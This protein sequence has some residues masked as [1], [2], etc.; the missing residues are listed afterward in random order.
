MADE[1]NRK[2]QLPIDEAI[3]DKTIYTNK[4]NFRTKSIPEKLRSEIDDEMS[5][6]FFCTNFEVDSIRT[7][8]DRAP[9]V[10][11]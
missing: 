4:C 7:P 1:Q 3:R 2:Q 11:A 10:R 5:S 8:K 9:R 6:H